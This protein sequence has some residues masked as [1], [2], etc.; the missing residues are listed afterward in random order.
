MNLEKLNLM[1]NL[2]YKY[3]FGNIFLE[4]NLEKLKM[5]NLKCKYKF[6]K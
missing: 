3:K 2:K 6:R 5:I 1:K 4:M